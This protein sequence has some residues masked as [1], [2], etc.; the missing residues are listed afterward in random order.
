MTSEE[1]RS[2]KYVGLIYQNHIRLKERLEHLTKETKYN[3]VIR[4]S[5]HQL[6]LEWTIPYPEEGLTRR[7]VFY[8]R[9]VVCMKDA[10]N[11]A[12]HQLNS[13]LFCDGSYD[14]EVLNYLHSRVRG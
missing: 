12:G 6:E 5:S 1:Y 3:K 14:F 9:K 10:W 13:Y 4:Q 2:T 11:L 7:T 8:I